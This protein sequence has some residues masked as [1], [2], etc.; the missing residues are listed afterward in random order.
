[1]YLFCVYIRCSKTSYYWQCF[2]KLGRP[3]STLPTHSQRAANALARLTHPASPRAMR[4]APPRSAGGPCR[5]GGPSSGRERGRPR[6]RHLARKFGNLDAQNTRGSRS[7]SSEIR[8]RAGVASKRPCT[9]RW[10]GSHRSSSGELIPRRR[11]SVDGA[12]PCCR[13]MQ[14]ERNKNALSETTVKRRSCA[15]YQLPLCCVQVCK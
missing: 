3:R 13:R 4:G 15:A 2:Q 5:A 10:S 6:T 1:M 9:A 14:P 8:M 11:R 12:L 7:A